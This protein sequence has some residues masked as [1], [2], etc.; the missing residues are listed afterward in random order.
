M[1]ELADA[2]DSKSSMGNYVWVQVPPS[3][4]PLEVNKDAADSTFIA[5]EHISIGRCYQQLGLYDKAMNSYLSVLPI[6]LRM[7]VKEN[8]RTIYAN[9]S[10]IY[11]IL[12]K[13]SLALNYYK[14][15]VMN[16]YTSL[17]ISLN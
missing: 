16:E 11:E 10:E 13:Q 6:S 14:K 2:L 8:L 15:Y 12:G 17:H 3:V 1:A 9:V 5:T 7:G 4:P